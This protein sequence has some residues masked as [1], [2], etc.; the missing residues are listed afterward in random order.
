NNN[1]YNTLEDAHRSPPYKMQNS[2]TVTGLE[3]E[4]GDDSVMVNAPER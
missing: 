1:D 3:R 2:A 4:Y